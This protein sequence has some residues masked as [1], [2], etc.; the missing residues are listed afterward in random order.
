MRR[1]KSD[2]D[3]R[4]WAPWRHKEE[5]DERIQSDV[6]ILWLRNCTLPLTGGSARESCLYIQRGGVDW[7]AM[8]WR[9]DRDDDDD[10]VRGQKRQRR[11]QAKSL[12]FGL[13]F[14]IFVSR[15]CFGDKRDDMYHKA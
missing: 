14:Q 1:L 9:D 3:W 12:S 8:S 4:Y 15:K 11:Q 7:P 2:A 13:L 10:G 6:I 5:R